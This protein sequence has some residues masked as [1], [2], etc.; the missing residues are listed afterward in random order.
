M[1]TVNAIIETARKNAAG[2]DLFGA[3]LTTA[4]QRLGRLMHEAEAARSTAELNRISAD[5]DVLRQLADMCKRS[6]ESARST[7]A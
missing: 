6:F 3:V 4:E 2:G 1:M 7:L 5:A